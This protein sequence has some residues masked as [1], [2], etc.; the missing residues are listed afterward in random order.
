MKNFINQLVGNF[1]GISE[2]T[3]LL[4]IAL[5][6]IWAAGYETYHLFSATRME[7]ADLFLLF[8]YAEV[9]GMVAAFY[10]DERIPVTIPIIIAITALARMILLQ[11]K[12]AQAVNILFESL[13]ILILSISAWIMSVKDKLSL[14]KLKL[15]DNK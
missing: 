2:K 8:I 6:T 12:D 4:G 11:T 7:L 14:E 13:G 9:L 3:L 15:R 10:K 5:A 1:I